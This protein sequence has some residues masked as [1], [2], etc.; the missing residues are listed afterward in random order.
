MRHLLIIEDE[1]CIRTAV[2]R[3]LE[4]SGYQVSAA[5][6]IES[7]IAPFSQYDL[8]LCDIRLPGKQGPEILAMAPGVPVIMMTA[9]ASVRS[10]VDAMKQGAFD[11]IAKPF[12]H[13]EL[14][15]LIRR[16]LDSSQQGDGEKEPPVL[17]AEGAGELVGHCAAMQQVREQMAKVAPTDAT[18]LIQGESGSGK[19][20]VARLIHLNSSRK[21]ANF[22][23]FNCAAV[24][25][26][27]IEQELFGSGGNETGLIS[28]ARGGTLFLDEVGELP[29]N[30]QARLLRLLQSDEAS[31]SSDTG[32]IRIIAAT[33]RNIR[34]LVQDHDFRSDLYFRLRVVEIQLPPLREREDDIIELAVHLLEGMCRQ[35]NR[36]GLRLNRESLEAIRR[37]DWPGNV[38]ELA[39]ALERAVIL[40]DGDLITP[41]LLDIDHQVSGDATTQ[42]HI[43]SGLSLEEYFRQF[44]LAHQDLLNETELARQLG[45]SRKTLWE[46]RQRF[47]IPRPG[48]PG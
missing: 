39:N 29:I 38:R 18:I 11:Y 32:D 25:E 40:A 14:L 28:Q 3:F 47:G 21:H 42:Q 37:Y 5:D 19:E 16:A 26:Q 2:S 12:D 30:A 31:V 48:K 23:A 6:S 45:I 27:H 4:R 9:Y 8:I 22:V 41:D 46:R 43:Q 34:Q 17:L 35:V 7:A 1:K 33:H 10:A 36:P 13:E 15:S 24:P 20:L 44:V